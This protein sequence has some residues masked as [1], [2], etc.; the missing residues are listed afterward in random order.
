MR[1]GIVLAVGLVFLALLVI[2]PVGAQVVTLENRNS[3]VEINTEDF[4]GP[5]VWVVDGINHLSSMMWFFRVGSIDGEQDFNSLGAPTV[6]DQSSRFVTLTWV[7]NLFE[8]ET[9]YH[10]TG[11]NAGSGFSDL[12]VTLSLTNTSNAPLDINLFQYCDFDMGGVAGNDQAAL[13]N[14]NVIK[15]W[16][17]DSMVQESVLSW[18]TAPTAWEVGPWM[19]LYNK[20]SDSS[21]TTLT[22]APGM[23]SNVGPTDLAWAFQWSYTVP[24]NGTIMIS[25]DIMI[26][27]VVPE[28]GS[29]LVLGTGLVGLVGLRRFRR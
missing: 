24:V 14:Q 16:A 17:E 26:T 11:G 29:L 25:K 3:L 8:V 4:S 15:Q 18:G 22:N 9:A 7:H 5:S 6:G 10:I 13:V 28:P 12:A 21:P 20:L 2:Q 23:G 1:K 27:P 19:S